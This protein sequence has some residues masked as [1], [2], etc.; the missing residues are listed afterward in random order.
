MALNQVDAYKSWKVFDPGRRYSVDARYATLPA[1]TKKDIR[2]HFPTGLVP[3]GCSIES[4]LASGEIEFVKTSGTT[5]V[6]VTNIW[7]QKWWNA[8]EYA[9]ATQKLLDA[10]LYMHKA[11]TTTDPTEKTQFYMMTEK[12]ASSVSKFIP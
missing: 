1:L 11:K 7:Y 8:S 10:Y 12:S 6:A 4:G 5:D 9:E 3:P 2:K